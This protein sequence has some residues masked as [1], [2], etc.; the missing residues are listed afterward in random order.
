MR[1]SEN[2]MQKKAFGGASRR[3]FLRREKT[4]KGE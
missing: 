1:I 3:P 4:E 2:K